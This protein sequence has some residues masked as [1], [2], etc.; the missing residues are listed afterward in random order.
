MNEDNRFTALAILAT[1]L[2]MVLT[3]NSS[4]FF[5][6][7]LFWNIL[8]TP[9]WIF[10]CF[11]VGGLVL[12]PFAVIEYILNFC[13]KKFE[14]LSKKQRLIIYVIIAVAVCIAFGWVF[15]MINKSSPN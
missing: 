15:A 7:N 3:F 2:M 11:L 9:I 4:Y 10:S 8:S 12:I 14:N 1:I 6:D 13:Q 5:G